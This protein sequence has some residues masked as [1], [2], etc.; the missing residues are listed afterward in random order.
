MSSKGELLNFLKDQ[1]KVEKK[2][3]DSLNSSLVEM[4]NPAVKGV[5]KGISLDSAKHA[6]MYGAAVKLLTEVSPALTQEHLDK[7]KSLVEE[8]IHLEL[9][10]IE[11]ISKKL[12]SI[13]N[14]KVRLLLSAILQD[15]T[16]HHKLLEKVLEILVRGETITEEDWWDVLWRN[17][18]F[19]GAPGG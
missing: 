9:E 14:E 7:Q 12:P 6:D 19:H 18:P 11:K 16:R 10:L 13:K 17:V 8:H 15:E 2:I 5:L 3:V 4:K 1:I